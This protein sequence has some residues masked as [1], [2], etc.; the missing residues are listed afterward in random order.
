MIGVG[1]FPL[2]VVVVGLCALP[3]TLF[4]DSMAWCRK[5]ARGYFG[6]S[7]SRYSQRPS[8][9]SKRLICRRTA[10]APPGL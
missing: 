6:N 4:F 9:R 10:G 2:H 7:P 5:A 3:T 1:P 8:N